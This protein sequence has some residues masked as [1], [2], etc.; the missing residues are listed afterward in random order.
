M[1]NMSMKK[2]YILPSLLVMVAAI[3]PGCTQRIREESGIDVDFN[4]LD[5]DSIPYSVFVDSISY[6]DLDPEKKC[7]IGDISNL[8][9]ID[10][11]I[12][13]FESRT[14]HIH[15]LNKEGKY[16]RDIGARG[17]GYGEFIYPSQINVDHAN[18]LILVYDSPKGEVLKYDL[19]NRYVGKDSIGNASD[20]FYLG[21]NRYIVT[22][23]NDPTD[24]S[25]IFLLDVKAHKIDK[26]SDCKDEIPMNKPWE[27]FRK[28]KTPVI[29]SRPYE[30]IVMEW[31]EG[32][33]NSSVKFNVSPSPSRQDL[34]AMASN[35]QDILKHPNR[36]IFLDS[37]RWFY[38]YYWIEDEVKYIFWDHKNRKLTLASSLYNDIDGVYGM[39]LPICIDNSFV[40]VVDSET[41]NGNPKLQFLHLKK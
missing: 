36:M 27:I 1:G 37:G 11:Y 28:E 38:S 40:K 8:V 18:K 3:L 20:L 19:D 29:M 32:R 13:L 12:V 35:P 30:D 22:K 16:L 39:E 23:F 25:G 26:L 15:L 14:Y 31:D 6:L 5:C 10:S 9:F 7:M 41:E 33:I 4:K 17:A 21:D 2:S 34:V 24:K